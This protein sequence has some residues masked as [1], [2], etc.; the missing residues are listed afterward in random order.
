MGNKLL[1]RKS[2]PSANFDSGGF[3]SVSVDGSTVTIVP[4]KSGTAFNDGWWAFKTDK[5]AGTIPTLV[6][7]PFPGEDGPT[8]SKKVRWGCYASSIDTDTWIDF[9]TPASDFINGV[10]L[11][12]ALSDSQISAISDAM[13]DL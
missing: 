1:L 12:A 5:F 9:A 2:V 10:T 6:I 3:V 4:N 8:M 7:E 11:T 13:N